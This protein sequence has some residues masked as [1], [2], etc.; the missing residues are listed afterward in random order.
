MIGYSQKSRRLRRLSR[1][2]QAVLLASGALVSK[3]AF[4]A[5][6]AIEELVILG[7]R[8]EARTATEVPVPVD[9]IRS[10]ALTK[11]GFTELGQS[12]QATAPSFNFSLNP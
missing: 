12:L 5:E 1:L 6:S 9:I 7:T 4:S 10:E 2:A 8:V 11:N 3:A